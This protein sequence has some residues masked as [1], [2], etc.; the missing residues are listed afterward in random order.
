MLSTIEDIDIDDIKRENTRA[1][2]HFFSPE[3]MAFFRSRVLPTVHT[4]GARVLF[5][6]SEQSWDS[7]RLY[8]VR[9]FHPDTCNVTTWGGYPTNR[10]DTAKAAHAAAR[11]FLD[12]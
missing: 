1:G 12:E 11:R 7:A 10:Y 2:Y 9:E 8:T 5:V 4:N 3:T 6:T